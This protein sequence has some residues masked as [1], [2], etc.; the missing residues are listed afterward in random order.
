MNNKPITN[1]NNHIGKYIA[2]I[3]ITIIIVRIVYVYIQIFERQGLNMDGSLLALW[4][5]IVKST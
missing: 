1:D 4:E 2:I 3:T 5:Y